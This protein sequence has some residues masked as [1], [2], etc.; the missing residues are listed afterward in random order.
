MGQKSRLEGSIR[1]AKF[2]EIHFLLYYDMHEISKVYESLCLCM[3][4]YATLARIS[5]HCG[6]ISLNYEPN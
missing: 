5:T 2:Q 3:T 6:K 4:F 1:W